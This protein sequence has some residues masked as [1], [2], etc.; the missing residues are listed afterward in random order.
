MVL[1]EKP[2]VAQLTNTEKEE[3]YKMRS[4]QKNPHFQCH[5][6]GIPP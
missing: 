4:G 1:D 2:I 6:Y 5:N 3:L